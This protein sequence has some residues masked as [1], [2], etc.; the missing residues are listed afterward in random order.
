MTAATPSPKFASPNAAS[1]ISRVRTVI[2]AE[3]MP[4]TAIR[5]V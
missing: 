4:P 5:S 1:V 2:G 3:A